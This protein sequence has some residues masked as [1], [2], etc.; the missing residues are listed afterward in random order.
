MIL[1]GVFRSQEPFEGHS[2]MT[3]H[4]NVINKCGQ[5]VSNQGDVD[6][7]KQTDN[8]KNPYKKN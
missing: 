8:F 3:P 4:C 1:S 5:K 2:S 6:C 7:D